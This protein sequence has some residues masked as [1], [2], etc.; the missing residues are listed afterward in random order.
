M[1]GQVMN[2]S[3]S[4]GVR[5]RGTALPLCGLL[6]LTAC[7]P[8]LAS[9]TTSEGAGS[10]TGVESTSATLDS[11]GP[12][13]TTESASTGAVETTVALTGSAGTTDCEFI[14]EHDLP[15]DNICDIF[16]QDCPEGQ[17]C[18]S[19]DTIGDGDWN[20]NQ[21]VEIMGDGEAGEP[22]AAEGASG[23]DTCAKGHMCWYLDEEFN[24]TCVA[25]C[26]GASENSMCADDC[27]RCVLAS[28]LALCLPNCDP[29]EQDCAGD[30]LCIGDPNSD[31]FVCVLDA[32]GGMAP[33]GTPCEFA[34]V[35]DP[36][37][38]CINPDAVPHPD[39]EGGIGCCAPFC[40]YEQPDGACDALV[41]EVP[42]IECV[43][44]HEQPPP[45]ESCLGP[46][47]VCVVPNP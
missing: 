12:G 26:A 38:L 36:G 30:A 28:P 43:P 23:H 34:N 21:C 4:W 33:A 42:K 6:W 44:Y 37:N 41:D 35:C 7:G 20:T 13:S 47:G 15:K 3:T 16:A 2:R 19:V 40:N 5:A 25:T 22:C 1:K 39:C 10:S 11:T 14:C 8:E 31:G 29:L 45:P 24:G 46:V 18:A 27:T 32:S 9:P 17:K